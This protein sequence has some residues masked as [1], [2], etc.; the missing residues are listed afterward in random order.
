MKHYKMQLAS[1]LEDWPNQ[2]SLFYADTPIVLHSGLQPDLAKSFKGWPPLFWHLSR[3]HSHFD[4]IKDFLKKP[5]FG[6]QTACWFHQT[7]NNNSNNRI[8]SV[9]MPKRNSK[10]QPFHNGGS[11]RCKMVFF[12]RKLGPNRHIM[13]RKKIWSRQCG[14]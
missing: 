13:R 4:C 5:Y 1:I 9:G 11:G 8:L 3:D 10:F 6:V 2:T 14:Q 12:S 7:N